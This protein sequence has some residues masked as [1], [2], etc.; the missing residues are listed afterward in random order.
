MANPLP[1]PAHPTPPQP[2]SSCLLLQPVLCGGQ[3]P[4]GP[5][6][7]QLSRVK[8]R[9]PARELSPQPRLIPHSAQRD[10]SRSHLGGEGVGKGTGLVGRR[11]EAWGWEPHNPEWSSELTLYHLLRTS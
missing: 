10:R 8:L 5:L 3:F 6:E 11:G 2:E 1:P 4:G 7:L 9:P